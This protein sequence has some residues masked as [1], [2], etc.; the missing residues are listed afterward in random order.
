MRSWFTGIGDERRPPVAVSVN[1]PAAVQSAQEVALRAPA[2]LSDCTGRYPS[3]RP[4]QINVC[5]ND[6]PDPPALTARQ[7]TIG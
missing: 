4:F 3:W 2:R 6:A 7:R 1:Q 5:D